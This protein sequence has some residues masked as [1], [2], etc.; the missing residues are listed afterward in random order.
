MGEMER[1]KEILLKHRGKKNA[2]KYREI[3][4]I[5][6]YPMEDTQR[7]CR[8]KIKQCEKLFGLPLGSCPDGYYIMQS[9]EELDEYNADMINRSDEI[10]KRRKQQNINFEKWN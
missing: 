3:S 7:V 5:M 6:G 2:I 1:I 10:E 4:A 8:A 9:Q